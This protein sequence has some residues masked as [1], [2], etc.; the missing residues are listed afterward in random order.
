MGGDL[1]GLGGRSPQN[2]RWGTAHAFAP[3]NILR[4]SVIGC[5]RKYE[6][7]KKGVTKD[8][9]RNRAL[10]KGHNVYTTFETV[11]TNEGMVDD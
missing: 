11:K 10:R 2:L 5:V 1:G 9:F 7:S 4:S 3:F 8:F 6:V